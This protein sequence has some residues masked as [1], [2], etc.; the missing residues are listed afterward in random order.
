MIYETLPHRTQP[1]LTV[2][3]H[4]YEPHRT[5]PPNRVT[6][7]CDTLPHRTIPEHARPDHTEMDL[8]RIEL[9]SSP[10]KGDVVPMN[11][12]SDLTLPHQTLPSPTS[13]RHD[14]LFIYEWNDFFTFQTI[15]SSFNDIL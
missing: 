13:A 11:Y 15:P 6:M 3:C 5:L 7:N 10:C 9:G 12:R 2:T 14:Y 8:P 4:E 1:D